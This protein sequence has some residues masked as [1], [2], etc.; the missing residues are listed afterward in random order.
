MTR[1]RCARPSPPSPIKGRTKGLGRDPDHLKV[2]PGCF[3]VIGDTV[4]EAREKKKRLDALV[5]PD[6]GIATLSVLLGADAS[7]FDLDAPLPEMPETNA[8][9]SARIKLT[10][11]SA[12]EGMTVRELAQLVGGSFGSLE[13]VGTASGIAEARRQ[14]A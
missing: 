9:Q 7:G 13:M 10:R 6:R 4:A 14:R 3:V 8:S 11:L 1:S 5:H 12:R 2:L